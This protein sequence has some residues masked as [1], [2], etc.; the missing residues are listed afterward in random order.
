MQKHRMLIV[1]DD[2][3][4][5]DGLRDIMR[6]EGYAVDVAACGEDALSQIRKENYE[7]ILSDLKLPG[8]GGMDVLRA[9]KQYDA[10]VT[11]IVITAYGTVDSAVLAMKSGAEDYVTKPFNIDHIRLVVRKAFE[12][13]SL[14]M[15]NAL[16]ESQ[17]RKKYRFENIIGNSEP[18]IAIYRLIEQ[19]KDSK[20]TVLIRGETGTGKELVARAIHFNSVRSAF[21]FIPVNCAALSENLAGS[22]LFGYAKGSFT[23]AFKDRRGI[24]ETAENGTI[25][26]DEIGDGS[27]ALQQMFLRVLEDG[28]IQPVGSAERKKVSVRI[29]AATNRDLERMVRD[30]KFREDLYYRIN[31]VA[32]DLPPLRARREDIGVLARH[33]LGKYACENRRSISGISTEALAV[34]EAHAWPGNVRELENVM[35]R[36][37]LL[38]TGGMIMPEDLPSHFPVLSSE[39]TLVFRSNHSLEQVGRNHIIEVLKST[40][41]NRTRAAEILGINRTTLWR[42]MQRLKVEDVDRPPEE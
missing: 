14:F 28:E 11:F 36:A 22:E 37:A 18:M 34:L 8:I 27:L 30:G 16:L 13:R 3:K 40:E 29:I 7:L 10:D 15:R 9:V 19:I 41:G 17:L 2:E 31:V 21:P 39:E 5:R 1:E 24:F 42:M 6:K 12:K 38:A 20:T 26:L 23:G 35:E 25:F 4:M 33:F 32:I